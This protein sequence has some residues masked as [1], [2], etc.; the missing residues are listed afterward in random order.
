MYT[1]AYTI[2]ILEILICNS[3]IIERKREKE[4]VN[5][6]RNP[7]N[8]IGGIHVQHQSSTISH[9]RGRKTSVRGILCIREVQNPEALGT[10]HDTVHRARRSCRPV[11]RLLNKRRET[12][13]PR[14]LDALCPCLFSRPLNRVGDSAYLRAAEALCVCNDSEVSCNDGWKVVS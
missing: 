9:R 14:L 3:L 11:G 13:T 12:R 1:Y 7:I 6:N 2:D 5:E 8:S 10:G 4:R